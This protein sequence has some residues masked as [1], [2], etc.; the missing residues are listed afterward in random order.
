MNKLIPLPPSYI[1]SA[2]GGEDDYHEG[3]CPFLHPKVKEEMEYWNNRVNAA[4]AEVVRLKYKI[5]LGETNL[6]E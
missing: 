5:A 3:G 6:Y 1:C 2:C 4:D